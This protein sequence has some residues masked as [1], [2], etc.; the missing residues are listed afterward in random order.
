MTAFSDEAQPAPPS[1]LRWQR[2]WLLSLLIAGILVAVATFTQLTFKQSR[3]NVIRLSNIELPLLRDIQSLDLLLLRAQSIIYE[4]YLTADAA[5]FKTEFDD[6]CTALVKRY[7]DLASRAPNAP[8]LPGIENSIDQL[9]QLGSRF[10]T[11]M[12]ATPIDWDRAREVLESLDPLTTALNRQSQALGRWISNRT[13]ATAEQSLV[14]LS[15]TLKLLS[16]ALLASFASALTLLWVNR[17]RVSAIARLDYRALHDATTGLRNRRAFYADAARHLAQGAEAPHA[18]ALVKL[19]RL[20]DIVARGGMTLGDAVI[21]ESVERLLDASRTDGEA[22][23]VLYRIDGNLFALVF[24]ERGLPRAGTVASLLAPFE[25]PLSAAGYGYRLTVS[26]GIAPLKRAGDDS[27]SAATPADLALIDADV[28]L[29][30]AEQRGGNQVVFFD[31]KIAAM[32]RRRRQLKRA[33]AAAVANG[34]L[35]LLYQPQLD[36]RTGEILGVE[37]LVR[38]Q[39]P[40]LGAVSPA[41]FIAIAEEDQQIIE[42]GD[43]VIAEACSAARAWQH[44]PGPPRIAINLSTRQLNH[45]LLLETVKESMDRCRLPPS[46]LEFEITESATLTPTPESE[47]NLQGLRALG[48]DLAIDDF[49]TGY[50]SLSYLHRLPVARLKIDRSFVAGMDDDERKQSSVRAIVAL[51]RAHGLETVAEGIEEE[52]ELTAVQH[53]GADLLQGFF[54]G[55]PMTLDALLEL[56]GRQAADA[57][58]ERGRQPWGPRTRGLENRSTHSGEESPHG[59]LTFPS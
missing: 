14:E 29:R 59:S 57:A 4:Y 20:Q 25:T 1:L 37:A 51:A 24:A 46:Q 53:L 54:L 19:D 6:N 5:V 35:Y 34:E 44:I 39:S 7:R 28:A 40:D 13:S 12:R 3:E 18:V 23:G 36:A 55:R 49:G 11:V 30:L 26:V 16:A 15:L 9:R 21:Q 31:E 47:R 22:P 43:W 32:A 10:D 50:S 56:L 52:A 45:G 17:S 27:V 41:E 38:W 2:G 8:A 58:G 42:L 33:L 48:I